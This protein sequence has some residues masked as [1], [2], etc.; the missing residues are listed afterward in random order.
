M[1]LK[2]QKWVSSQNIW[3]HQGSRYHLKCWVDYCK[4]KCG[5][6]SQTLSHFGDTNN[7]WRQNI[8]LTFC[9]NL[10]FP[11]NFNFGNTYYKLHAA[12]RTKTFRDHFTKFSHGELKSQHT[13]LFQVLALV[14][15]DVRQKVEQFH[16]CC[17]SSAMFQ[18]SW[19]VPSWKS[20]FIFTENKQ[21]EHSAI[22]KLS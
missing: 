1:T 18:L 20:Y 15:Y 7:L 14:I 6:T 12:F 8:V 13:D 2:C 22:K 21:T 16:T 10:F 3:S 9:N 11:I 17:T 19:N 5:L 4:W